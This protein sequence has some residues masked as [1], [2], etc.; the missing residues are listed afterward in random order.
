MWEFVFW[1]AHY[2]E[3]AVLTLY[4]HEVVFFDRYHHLKVWQLL[5]NVGEFFVGT[6][7]NVVTIGLP[8]NSYPGTN[9]FDGFLTVSVAP[10]ILED[11]C[12][13][14][15]IEGDGAPIIMAESKT[16]NGLKYWRGKSNGVAA[17]TF[18]ESIIYHAFSGGTCYEITLNEFE[19]NIGNYP[20]GTVTQVDK[21]D[22]YFKLESVLNTFKLTPAK[23]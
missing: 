4:M 11:L 17:G 14:G 8:Q 2:F 13:Q 19:G 12:K 16:I 6:G 23:K 7:E 1:Q 3:C 15:Q 21:N 18:G 22:V 9:F 20:E 5:Y 10:G